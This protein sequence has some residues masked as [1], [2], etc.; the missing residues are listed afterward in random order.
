[1]AMTP[2][3][4]TKQLL[5]DIVL[6]GPGREDVYKA[7]LGKEFVSGLPDGSFYA[8]LISEFGGDTTDE[9]EAIINEM[10]CVRNCIFHAS[11]SYV[12]DHGVLYL[13][14]G[15]KKCPIMNEPHTQRFHGNVLATSD[16]LQVIVSRSRAFTFSFIMESMQK[17]VESF[18]HE[19][20]PK[21]DVEFARKVVINRLE[22][23]FR[24]VTF[25]SVSV[26][27]SE[28]I[29]ASERFGPFGSMVLNHAS[30]LD[31]QSGY[32]DAVIELVKTHPRFRP[33]K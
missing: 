8:Y 6:S 23:E 13:L 22:N 31:R 27:E 17:G 19:G 9:R 30:K 11:I 1:M 20:A 5:A 26:D 28:M 10:Y 18:N 12:N 2:R 29:N 32:E 15:E 16:E 21:E 4:V 14:K 33:Q 7:S 3:E 24:G 25:R